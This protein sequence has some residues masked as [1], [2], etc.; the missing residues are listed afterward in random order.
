MPEREIRI[1]LDEW[2]RGEEIVAVERAARDLGLDAEVEASLGFRSVEVVAWHVLVAV[3]EHGVDWILGG[4]VGK[5]GIEAAAKL[6]DFIRDIGKAREDAPVESGTVTIIDQKG[7][8]IVFGD[9]LPDEA[10]DKLLAESWEDLKGGY[11]LW[12][13]ERREWVDHTGNRKPSDPR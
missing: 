5:W 4:I 9:E 3:A 11:L 1:S 6:R 7:N 10:Y 13:E 8:W 12:D 2:A